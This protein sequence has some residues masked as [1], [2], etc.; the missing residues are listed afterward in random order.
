MK[1]GARCV[2]QDSAG[3]VFHR[4][5]DDGHPACTGARALPDNDVVSYV[6]DRDGWRTAC[7]QCYPDG[8]PTSS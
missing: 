6:E 2:W 8:F 3:T 4:V 5:A 7:K 1:P